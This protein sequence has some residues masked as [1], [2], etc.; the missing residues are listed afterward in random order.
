ML[1]NGR[2]IGAKGGNI[3]VSIPVTDTQKEQI[4]TTSRPDVVVEFEDGRQITVKQRKKIYVLIKCIADWQGYTPT[5]VTKELLK[6]EFISS[7]IREAISSDDSFSLS[8]CDRTTARLFITWLIE[9]CL[10][11]D[12][13]C[14]EPLWKLCEDIEKY[15]WACVVTKHCA[16]CGKKA[17]LHHYDTVGT[18]RNRKEIC[19]I[20]MRCLPLCR[21]HHTQIHKI[22]R[23]EFCK[24]YILEPIKIDEKIAQAYKLKGGMM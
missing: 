19:H 12:I 16:V 1:L 6:Y 18:G 22:G 11:H 8:D 3:F 4:A 5:E 23:D 9:F 7:P 17:E 20:G 10:T 2:V 14:G 13:P 24:R 15:M 21:K